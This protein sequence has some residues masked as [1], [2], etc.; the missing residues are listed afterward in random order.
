MLND[1]KLD[2]Y[3][4]NNL[5]VLFEGLHGVGKTHII[6]S[7]FQRNN[8]RYAYFSGA[9]MDPYVDFVGVPVKVSTDNGEVLRF[10]RPEHLVNLNVQVIFM[11]E[12]NRAHKKVRNALMELIQ[13]KTINGVPFSNDLRAVWAAINPDSDEDSVYDTD[14]LDPAQRDRFQVQVQVPYLCDRDYFQSKHGSD[15]GSVAIEFWNK[16]PDDIRLKV[17]PRRLDYA[18]DMWKIGGDIRDVLP[19]ESNPSVLLTYLKVGPVAEVLKN[20]F[21]TKQS[22][23]AKIF[24][25][26]LNNLQLATDHI[27]KSNEYISYFFPY[28]PKEQQSQLFL[29]NKKVF[30]VI[31]DEFKKLGSHESLIESI[32]KAKLSSATKNDL[33]KLVRSRESFLAEQTKKK[34]AEMLAANL[35]SAI[36]GSPDQSGQPFTLTEEQRQKAS[37]DSPSDLTRTLSRWGKTI[38]IYDRAIVLFMIDNNLNNIVG[39]N[40]HYVQSWFGLVHQLI[41]GRQAR[42]LAKMPLLRDVLLTLFR[43]HTSF[44]AQAMSDKK[45]EVVKK[46]AEQIGIL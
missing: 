11:D 43:T 12:L 6:L 5:N 23:D 29:N 13:F 2:F 30:G 33:T 28:M 16:L 34:R 19:K 17:S 37:N 32:S 8:L 41:N 20:L 35:A 25:S 27:A 45:Y 21:Q 3:L 36:Q 26:N 14:R 38:E 9:T 31:G 39:Y 4:Q 7:A 18:L 44:S 42:T 40:Q 46:Y 15:N 10:I 22:T 24:L 1:K